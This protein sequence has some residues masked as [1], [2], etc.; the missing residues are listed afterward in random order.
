MKKNVIISDKPNLPKSLFWEFK[1]DEIDWKKSY[2]SVMM[3]VLERGND[4][5][6]AEMICFYGRD[7][8]IDA[9]KNDIPDLYQYAIDELL[10][11]FGLKYEELRAS[12][13]PAW[14]GPRWR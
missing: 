7:K 8:V 6:K 10:P 9:L 5:E 2:I 4:E 12:K 13:R 14:R 3:R 11:Y 1:Y